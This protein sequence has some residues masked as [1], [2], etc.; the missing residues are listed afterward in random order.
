[1]LKHLLQPLLVYQCFEQKKTRTQRY[2]GSHS[3]YITHL[4]N[5]VERCQKVIDTPQ[6]IQYHRPRAEV[7]KSVD[8]QRSG[9]CTRKGVGVRV[10]PSAPHRFSPSTEVHQRPFH[11]Q[12]ALPTS[13][14]IHQNLL[15]SVGFAVSF[16]REN[17]RYKLVCR[18]D[19][20]WKTDNEIVQK[21]STHMMGALPNF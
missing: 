4:N 14:E 19:G 8:T 12:K 18:S 3:N 21:T 11:A 10:P 13:I 1:M 2:S 17:T 9:R 5:S 7:V 6:K 20:P 16:S 15:M